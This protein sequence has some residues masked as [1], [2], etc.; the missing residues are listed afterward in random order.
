M[1]PELFSIPG[2]DITIK[3]YGLLLG[4]GF[5]CALALARWRCRRCGKNP[6]VISS[7]AMVALVAGLIGARAMHVIHNFSDFRSNP[8]EI[9]AI[10]SG[11][12][13]FLGGVIL[14]VLAVVFYLKK[15]KQPILAFL[16]M[17]A[18]AM[19][20]GLAL[21]RIGCFLNGCCFGSPCELP[22][23]V[24]FPPVVGYQISID[25]TQYSY[26]YLYQLQADPQRRIDQGPLLRL[27]DS[28]YWSG[29]VP[30][31]DSPGVLKAVDQL[32]DAQLARLIDGEF[33]MHSIHPSQL[34]SAANALIICLILTM[35]Y[36]LRNR[37]GQIGALMLLLYGTSRFFLEMLRNDS[38]L[39]WNG[40]TISQN[41]SIA[42]VLIG[43][44]ILC[45][46]RRTKRL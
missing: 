19:M 40:L 32:T 37:D 8:L 33:P 44:A 22:W 45:V 10:W 1:R 6:D 27:P 38:P 43:V 24:Q 16:D 34:Y 35:V 20:L 5:L 3:S 9:L 25:H 15:K 14:G 29:S 36:R 46:L 23:A 12:L 30:A 17:L 21:G 7:V 18:P 31:A 42:S 28:Y 2:L 11:G 39:E 4:A 13:E 41:I 26:P